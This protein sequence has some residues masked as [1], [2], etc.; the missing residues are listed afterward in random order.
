VSNRFS[1]TIRKS[2]LGAAITVAF[3]VIAGSASAA[4]KSIVVWAEGP[5]KDVA[6]AQAEAALGSDYTVADAGKWQRALARQG[7]RGPLAPELSD[8]KKRRKVLDQLR[9]AARLVE[10]DD[11][12]VVLTHRTQRG[13]EATLMVIDPTT[14]DTPVEKR[15][16]LNRGDDLSRALQQSLGV[17]PAS[18]DSPSA[19]TSSS[20]S[21][22]GAVSPAG[23]AQG[24]GAD[25]DAG[26]AAAAPGG[27]QVGRNLF[28]VSVGLEAGMRHFA[29]TDGLTSNLRPYTLSGAPLASAQA[30]IYPFAGSRALDFGVVLGYARSFGLQSAAPTGGKLGTQWSRS[31]AGAR[32]RV[33]T[34]GGESPIVGVIAAYGEEAFDIDNTPSMQLPVVDYR[35]VRT[36]AD[37]RVPIGRVAFIADGGFLAVLSA[38]DVSARVRGTTFGGVEAQ[39][40]GAVTIVPG[41]EGRLIASYRRF[42]Y[43]MRPIPG[44][45]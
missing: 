9:R 16:A 11:V 24:G 18:S 12:V 32:A 4:N 20:L 38:G 29:Y 28:E 36:S 23:S 26:L 30:E 41:L 44:D 10:A 5:D 15:V 2:G 1:G 45:T 42:F 31:Y 35:F 25:R 21:A 14:D 7:E 6:S 40:G 17:A 34:G 13:S 33:R 37:L 39:L 3:S 8:E 27:H 22:E 43:S 19:A